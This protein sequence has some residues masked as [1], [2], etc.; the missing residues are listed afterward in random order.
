MLPNLA[1]LNMKNC[2]WA[3]A[4][5]SRDGRK[6]SGILQNVSDFI[7]I[8]FGISL[9]YSFGAS[10]SQQHIFGIIG[11]RSQSKVRRV[12]TQTIVARMQ[13]HS[14]KRKWIKFVGNGIRKAMDKNVSSFAKR[15]SSVP[16]LM[17]IACPFNAAIRHLASIFGQANLRVFYPIDTH[18]VHPLCSAQFTKSL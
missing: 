13:N 3:Y 12:E 4:V 17:N 7:L 16:L 15:R 8:K 1:L 10:I 18:A 6:G 2:R 11:M 14:V 9:F 5:F